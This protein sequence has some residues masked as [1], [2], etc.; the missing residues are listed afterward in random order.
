MWHLKKWI[1]DQ[2]IHLGISPFFFWKFDQNFLD[3]FSQIDSFRT[4]VGQTKAKEIPE[5]TSHEMAGETELSGGHVG[6]ALLCFLKLGPMKYIVM[7]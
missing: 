3:S 1:H 6:F 2:I 5:E 7:L 4:K